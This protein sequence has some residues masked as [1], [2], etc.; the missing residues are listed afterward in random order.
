MLESEEAYQRAGVKAPDPEPIR[1]TAAGAA[2]AAALKAI[3]DALGN[4]KAAFFAWLDKLGQAPGM[5]F[6][7]PPS[8]RETLMSLPST[9]F[10]VE[11]PLL[12]TRVRT[13][14]ELP[15]SFRELLSLRRVDYE[16]F[17][18]ESER[19]RK[20]GGPADALKALSSLVEENPGDAVLARDVAF[21]AM[22]YGLGGHAYHLF[23]RVAQARPHEPQTYRALAAC[24]V[25]MKRVDSPSR[26]TRS[27]WPGVGRPVRRLPPHPRA[28]VRAHPAPHRRGRAQHDAQ[29]LRRRPPGD[30]RPASGARSRPIWWW[31]I[32]WNTDH[33]D[34]DL[35]VV[36]PGGE[37]CF[38]G[39]RKTKQ[40][41]EI[42]QDVT[43]G[44]GPE[45]YVLPKAGRGEYKIRAHYYA[46]DRNRQSARTKVQVMVFEGW[47]TKSER[48]TDKVVTLALNQEKH[49]V[50][51]VVVP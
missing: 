23:R 4:P 37:E 43:Q 45:M 16:P 24:L 1:K 15:G 26:I 48:V 11:A 41:G 50:A 14:A 27:A 21:S 9:A 39:H 49:D 3:G 33:T 32:T 2:I 34:V 44:Y 30:A 31:S 19:R 18:V 7:P 42:T 8:L 40:G 17:T 5:R 25:D 38:Y 10:A 6:T 20:A 22:S 29:G 13:A 51:T 28:G 47:G 36:E 12:E 35:H 46:S